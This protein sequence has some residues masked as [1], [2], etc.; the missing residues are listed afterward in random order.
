M[1]Q[2]EEF[3][4]E[5]HKEKEVKDTPQSFEEMYDEEIISFK[6]ISN[7]EYGEP[8]LEDREWRFK[9]EFRLFEEREAKECA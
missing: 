5:D 4:C 7:D 1:S 8:D 6:V 9:E 3:E 2:F